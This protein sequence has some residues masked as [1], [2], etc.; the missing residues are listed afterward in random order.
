MNPVHHALYL[1]RCS[2]A[3]S[4]LA[5]NAAGGFRRRESKVDIAATKITCK[6]CLAMMADDVEMRLDR[7]R[8]WCPK[9]GGHNISDCST[10][11]GKGYVMEDPD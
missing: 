7:L 11:M 6:D 9:C 4:E 8:Y 2:T 3:R 1:T 5:E 10:C